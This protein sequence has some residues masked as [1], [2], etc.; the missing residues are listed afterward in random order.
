MEFNF[1]LAIYWALSLPWNVVDMPSETPFEKT[2]F[3]FP[4]RYQL[5]IAYWLGIRRLFTFQIKNSFLG[6][7][8]S[9]HCLLVICPFLHGDC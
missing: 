8:A 1:S 7:A 9:V 6:E 4:G 5:Q 2:D 3:P